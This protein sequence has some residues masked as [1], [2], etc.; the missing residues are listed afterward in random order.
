MKAALAAARR[1]RKAAIPGYAAD[2]GR[3]GGRR[4]QAPARTIRRSKR[5]VVSRS[6]SRTTRR[7]WCVLPT[8]RPRPKTSR[9]RSHPCA[10]P[11]PSR[12]K[13]LAS[14]LRL[15]ACTRRPVRSTP[16]SRRRGSSRR[17]VR[18]VAWALR[19]KANCW[20]DRGSCRRLR[21]SSGLR[22]PSS[23]CPFRRYGCMGSCSRW[24]SRTRRRRSSQKWL[25]DIR[26]TS[27]CGSTSAS[28]ASRRATSS[29]Q[30]RTFARRSQLE[31]DNVVMLNN[32]AWAMSETRRRRRIEYAEHA[33]RLAPNS[34][35]VANTY[36][37][38]LVQRGDAK[39]GIELL[40]KSVDL[41]PAD[42]AKRLLP[43]Q[44]THQDRRQ[45]GREDRAR[46]GGQRGRLDVASRGGTAAEGTLT[47]DVEHAPVCLWK[48]P[49]STIAARAARR[50]SLM[51]SSTTTIAV[52]GLGY[53]GLP[54][55]VEFG[56]KYRTIG[57][58][59]SQAK[60]DAYRRFV[61]PTGEVATEDLR[62]ATM[63]RAHDGRRG[64]CAGRLHRRRGA[65]TDRRRPSA[66]LPAAAGRERSGRPQHEARRDDRVR[67]DR[68][69]GR[70]RGNLRA[71][72]REAFGHEV[73][74]GLLRRL[75]ARAH[76]SR[77]PRAHADADH[78][79]R[80]GRHAGNARA[81]RG[82][83]T[84]ASSR[85]AC[86]ARAASRWRRPRRSSRT[87]SATSTSR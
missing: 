54:L 78:Q 4:R 52:V 1:R 53:V 31:P 15:P 58:D 42:A 23:K 27:R 74:A 69:S 38:I 50:P 75:F 48:N 56:K 85:R 39:R 33:Y 57:F 60:V 29:P 62:Q 28:R 44:R 9:A 14:G 5:F 40:R 6:C 37:W 79:G 65:D 61:D 18:A 76:Q 43:R 25:K 49:L 11:W 12:R 21:Q 47:R 45:G 59:L 2:P 34:A 84:A 19:S 32:L 51:T 13:V 46:S 70:D 77:R 86:I 63:L 64:A 10:V 24:Q 72:D 3:A 71:R 68:L 66:G 30:C 36:G 7:R 67:I 35:E 81:R 55:A 16:V 41:A 20:R 73:E 83:S 17:I 8:F 80:L 87:R 82:A 26:K 22:S